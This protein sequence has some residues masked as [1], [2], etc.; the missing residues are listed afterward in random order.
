MIDQKY[1][2]AIATGDKLLDAKT[3]D[4]ARVAYLDASGIKP[5][6]QYPKDKIA[7]IDKITADILHQKDVETQ[8]KASVV[9]ADQLLSTRSYEPAKT[10]YQDASATQSDC[11]TVKDIQVCLK[12]LGWREIPKQG[13]FQVM[14]AY[15]DKFRRH[16]RAI[17]HQ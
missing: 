8:Y 7:Q 11:S 15:S 4:L 12:K 17:W 16:R 1:L 13:D 9:K 14:Y 3:Y 2:T 10:E 5:A 6:E